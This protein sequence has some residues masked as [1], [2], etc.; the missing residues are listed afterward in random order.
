MS[1]HESI[2][3]DTDVIKLLDENIGNPEMEHSINLLLT[4]RSEEF[5]TNHKVLLK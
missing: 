4:K 2:K 5:G 1:S 3:Y